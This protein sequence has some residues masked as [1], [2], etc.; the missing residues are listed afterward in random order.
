[1]ATT[2]NYGSA[3]NYPSPL[4]PNTY[5]PVDAA[6]SQHETWIGKA[7]YDLQPVTDED[8]VQADM[9]WNVLGRTA[10]QQDHLVHNISVHLFAAVKA[11]RERTYGM[12]DHVN[13]VLG[14][15]IRI[16][17]EKVRA[18]KGLVLIE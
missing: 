12:F 14:S 10:D 9:L 1:M 13:P 8:Y 4:R 3:P 2:S 16:A 18:E 11:V 7:V 5:E 15:R 17:T 6:V